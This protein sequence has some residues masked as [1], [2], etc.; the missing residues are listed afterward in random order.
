M[1]KGICVLL[2]NMKA[3]SKVINF[4][5][6][7]PNYILKLSP[8]HN[9][10][11]MAISPDRSHEA[12]KKDTSFLNLFKFKKGK[13]SYFCHFWPLSRDMDIYFVPWT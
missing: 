9:F 6:F 7:Q 4:I 11:W 3:S 2:K 5:I 12:L 8:G 10:D 1:Q 13:G